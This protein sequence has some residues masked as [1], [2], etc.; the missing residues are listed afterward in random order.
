[1][2][3]DFVPHAYQDYAIQK[4]IDNKKY[5]LF[6]DMGLGKTVST[7]TAINEL[8]YDH[9]EVERVLVIAPKRVA[10]D[11]WTRET[12]KWKHL[13]H[14]RISKVLGNVKQRRKALVKE[15]DIYVI[16]RE[17]VKWL[18]DEYS[19]RRTWPFDMVVID[20]LSSFKNSSSVRFK[21]LKK[22]M[23]LVERFV[24]LTGT[25]APNSLLDL[26]SQ[27][28][29]IDS[30]ERL[31]KAYSHY[32]ERYFY[33][34][35]S[36]GNNVFKWKAKPEAEENIYNLIDDIC[37]SMKAQDYLEMPERIDS[38]KEVKLEDKER[39]LYEKL[40]KEMIL[41]FTE[42]DIVALNGAS[43]SQKLLQLSN[44]ASYNDNKG[45][46]HIHDRKIEMLKDIVEESQ[47]SP[48]LIFYNFKHD[49]ARIL[50]AFKEAKT[51]DDEDAIYHWNN[52]NIPMLLVHP[53]SAGHGLNLQDGGHIIAW[54]GLTWSLELYQQANARL[55]RQ[56][57]EHT[58][59]IHHILTEQSID[60]RVYEVLQ[61]K[62]AG[63]EALLKA[64][65]AR[66]KEIEMEGVM[67]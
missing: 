4:I 63:Q 17:N 18:C 21:E 11:T 61:G 35:Q 9:L 7:L 38:V 3:I 65:D 25:P 67:V 46:Q 24:G 66:M 58:T 42:G 5:G 31:G 16:N 44:G 10:E 54:Y 29:L 43:L 49:K 56:G 60:Q 64:I 55:Y 53:A 30:G 22:K 6:L 26:W 36:L 28:Y 13:N 27:I 14:L 48:I 37:V 45:V 15:A 34:A 40:E 8:I 1:M 47:G 2:A 39:T 57:Q 41:E 32:R 19:G 52:G 23:P 50:E 33:P 12:S 20:E 59:V 62:E 51:L